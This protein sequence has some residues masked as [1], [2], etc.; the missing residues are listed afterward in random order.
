MATKTPMRMVLF[1]GVR[2]RGCTAPKK[3]GGHH[4]VARHRQEH[5]RVRQS[6]ITSSTEVMPATPAVAMMI[7]R[8]RAARRA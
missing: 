3:L 5:P 8:P 2:N 7:S 4:A 6:I 1:H